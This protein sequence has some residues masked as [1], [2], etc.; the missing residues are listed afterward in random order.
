M[1]SAPKPTVAFAVGRKVGT[2]VVRNRIRRRIRAALRQYPGGLP[3]G[4]YLFSA[5][6]EVATIGFTEL[7]DHLDRV[8]GE[9]TGS[10]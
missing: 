3:S 1:V 8:V 7:V 2:A 4:T 5:W 6:R 9:V 10:G